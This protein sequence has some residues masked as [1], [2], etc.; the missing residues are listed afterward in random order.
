MNILQHDVH[1]QPRLRG[2]EELLTPDEIIGTVE[3]RLKQLTMAIL[4]EAPRF[5]GLSEQEQ[6]IVSM[7]DVRSFDYHNPET[8]RE[9]CNSDFLA[10]AHHLNKG[11]LSFPRERCGEVC[12]GIDCSCLLDQYITFKERVCANKQRFEDAWFVKNE[13]GQATWSITNVLSYFQ[14]TEFGLHE[15]IPDVVVII[16]LCLIMSRSQSDTE[17]L[18]KDVA[19]KRFGGK[20]NETHHDLKKRDRVNEEMFI[21]GNSVPLHSLPLK[22]LQ[23]EQAKCHLPVI[24]RTNPGKESSTLRTLRN[25]EQKIGFWFQ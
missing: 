11:N 7:F 25:K 1:F 23:K 14:K 22:E 13:A 2:H 16:A 9:Q 3:D 15:Q 19:E 12:T 17:K 20:F 24:L 4:Q 18:M 8:L 5:L 21:Y 10:F 6:H